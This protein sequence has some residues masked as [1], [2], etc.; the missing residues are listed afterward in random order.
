MAQTPK[1][2]LYESGDIFIREDLSREYD[3]GS[4][5]FVNNSAGPVTMPAGTPFQGATMA[6]PATL[7]A[8]DAILLEPMIVPV[9]GAKLATLKLGYGVVINET[10]IYNSTTNMVVTGPAGAVTYAQAALRTMWSRLGFVYR[11]EPARQDLQTR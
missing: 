4:I 10:L 1:T 5:N 2:K 3:S 6:D 7:T 11:A 9:G 8:A